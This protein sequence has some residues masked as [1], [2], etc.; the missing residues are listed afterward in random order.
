MTN[1]RYCLVWLAWPEACFRATPADIRYLKTLVPAGA[2]VACVRTEAAFLRLLPRATH[3]LV[4]NFRPAWF[5]RAPRLKVLATPAAGRELV[6]SVAPP[7]VTVHFGGFHGKIISET[8]LAFILG[9]AHG[10]FAK[11]PAPRIPG[12]P[13]AEMSGVCR[14]VAGTRAV[15]AGY[16]RI[17]R[18]IGARLEAQGVAVSGFGRKNLADLPAAAK[19][20]D[21][22]ILALPGDTGTTNF[23]DRR[24]L[25]KLPRRCVVV[26]VGRG[27]AVDEPALFAALAAGRLAGAYLDVR[28][29]EP[30]FG[31]LGAKRRPRA[32]QVGGR[33]LDNLV[34]MPHSCAFYREYIKDFMKELHDE[35]LL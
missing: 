7:G 12:W 33:R 34:L 6:P 18:A 19:A 17:G 11:F 23:L 32:P 30:N 9:W 4:W 16:G 27:N 31:N 3:A 14:A 5:A 13:R 21:W 10:F 22:F 29:D 26:N 8:V 15:I 25:A 20:A 2:R 1:S 35:G 28:R 24:L